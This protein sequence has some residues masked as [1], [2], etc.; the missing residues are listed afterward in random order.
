VGAP[1]GNAAL[2]A[3]GTKAPKGRAAAT[4]ALSTAALQQKRLQVLSSLHSCF[5]SCRLGTNI[6]HRPFKQINSCWRNR[7]AF[8]AAFQRAF[9]GVPGALHTTPTAFHQL[10]ALM[11][12]DF[13]FSLVRNASRITLEPSASSSSG[14][15]ATG[16]AVAAAAAE[17]TLPFAQLSA[18]LFI[19]FFFSEFMNQAALAFRTLD[20]SGAGKIAPARFRGALAAIVAK[21]KWCLSAVAGEYA[22]SQTAHADAAGLNSKSAAAAAAA[23]VPDGSDFVS[24]PLSAIEQVLGAPPRKSA[25]A[26]GTGA[27]AAAALS[28][29]S[30][31]FDEDLMFN[32][33]C[34]RLFQHP[35]MHAPIHSPLYFI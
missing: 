25:P 7:K 27:A 14:S 12:H 30:G 19:L 34:V 13:P 23:S 21:A 2:K 1:G 8:I 18:K 11:C 6:L 5:A 35:A 15:G 4:Y 26:V 20:T 31:A 24:P 17:S 16:A 29:E 22:I 28:A 32:A 33:F 10:C 3:K 9:R